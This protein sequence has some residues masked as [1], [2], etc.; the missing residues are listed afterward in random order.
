MLQTIEETDSS[1]QE[2]SETS[3]ISHPP[4]TKKAKRECHFDKSWMKQFVGIST[5]SNGI[6][7]YIYINNYCL[8][9]FTY[10][11]K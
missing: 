8:K 2:T 5:S 4:A 10:F 9:L 3:Q 7:Y 1:D 11:R 6:G